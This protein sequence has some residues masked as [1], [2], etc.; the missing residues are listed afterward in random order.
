MSGINVS[1]MSYDFPKAW[2]SEFVSNTLV[3]PFMA[4]ANIRDISENRAG[5]TDVIRNVLEELEFTVSHSHE[6][7]IASKN[8]HWVFTTS[9]KVGE[10]DTDPVAGYIHLNS[11]SVEI[12]ISS[13]RQELSSEILGKIKKVIPPRESSE[14]DHVVPFRFWFVNSNGVLEYRDR[15]IYCPHL[16][17]LE[18]NYPR[19]VFDNLKKLSSL[20]KPYERG[21]IILLHGP[22][23]TGK[24]YSIR[25]LA[26][27]WAYKNNASVEFILDPNTLLGNAGIM[28]NLFLAE[29]DIHLPPSKGEDMDLEEEIMEDATRLRLIII[30]D[31]A[32]MFS[33]NC[34]NNP[35]F[36]TLL[37][38]TDGLIGQGLPVVFLFTA[39]E[40]LGSIDSAIMRSGRCL[41]LSYFGKLSKEEANQWL[42][43]HD[44]EE[45]VDDDTI[46]ADL[47][48]KINKDSDLS[49]EF[50]EEGIRGFS[51]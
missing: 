13:R 11:R 25:A 14:D 45:R 5:I 34:R 32:D 12:L 1:L 24:T 22:P 28:S 47:Y 41:S 9:S 44:S 39:N 19:N 16:E 36:S 27:D 51:E 8:Y 46:L 18:G 42:E 15:D 31:K 48:A 50:S 7:G 20:K 6:W 2:I 30:E 17:D 29:S 49:L 35:A 21:K 38:L 40:A 37:N 43:N 33:I 10:I 26:R 3:H 4:S 23:G